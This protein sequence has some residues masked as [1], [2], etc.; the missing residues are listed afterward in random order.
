MIQVSQ[1]WVPPVQ[2]LFKALQKRDDRFSNAIQELGSNLTPGLVSALATKA[3]IDG[4]VLS[5]KV[6]L[7]QLERFEA[8]LTTMQV[9]IPPPPATCVAPIGE[10]LIVEGLKRRF[11]AEFFTSHTRPP[12]VY[13]G[14]PFV[15]EVGMAFGGELPK[16]ES[17]V[18]L[19]FANRVPL[20]YNPRAGAT[21]ESVVRIT[22]KVYGK[23][24]ALNQRGS[25]L[26][27]GPLAVLVHMASV[28]VPFTN[29]A[30]EAIAS[31]DEIVEEIRAA[32]ME[33]GRKL[34]T[35]VNAQQ[36][37]KWQHERKS[38]FEKY[39][40]EVSTSMASLYRGEPREDPGSTSTRRCRTT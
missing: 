13:R 27:V 19:R 40:E 1:A 33:C 26:L 2:R 8:A 16:D 4:A 15:V 17:A 39:T 5:K 32:L 36:A 25:E 7:T 20:L 28:W 11:K 30:K 10:T 31:Y 34:G 6:E 12:A 9:R 21:T 29:E 37:E 24:G 18:V 14:N 3:H 35:W 22:W 38:L 23:D